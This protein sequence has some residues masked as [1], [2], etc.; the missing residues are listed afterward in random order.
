MV[1]DL[2]VY[3]CQVAHILSVLQK[4]TF[5]NN[6][7]V[8]ALPSQPNGQRKLYNMLYMFN[9]LYTALGKTNITYNVI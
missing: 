1:L 7:G 4:L 2:Q 5:L 8:N 3:L 9:H 6:L